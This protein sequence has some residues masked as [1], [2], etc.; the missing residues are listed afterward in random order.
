MCLVQT[1]S[2]SVMKQALYVLGSTISSFHP[3]AGKVRILTNLLAYFLSKDKRIARQY[4]YSVRGT[5][6]VVSDYSYS[7]WAPHYSVISAISSEGVL[8]IRVL[9][10]AGERLDAQSFIQF[11]DE[12]LLPA[13]NPFNG[14]NPRCVLVMGKHCTYNS[15]NILPYDCTPKEASFFFTYVFL[16]HLSFISSRFLLHPHRSET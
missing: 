14:E 4:G 6:P 10:N 16:C 11:L 2:F 5:P 15:T 9:N 7:R 8:A 13:M 3:F 12:Q 1:S